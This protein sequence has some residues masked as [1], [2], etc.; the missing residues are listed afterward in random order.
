MGMQNTA[1][2]ALRQIIAARDDIDIISKLITKQLDKEENEDLEALKKQ[3]GKVKKGL[4]ELEKLYRTPEKTKGIVYSGDTVNSRLGTAAF[5][6]GSAN[7]APSPAS[8]TYLEIARKSL[9]KATDEANAFMSADL[10]ELRE[11]VGAAGITLLQV[12]EL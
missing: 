3:A 1:N 6:A 7:G 4:D 10:T 11:S 2:K 9:A 5:Y 8:K 12:N